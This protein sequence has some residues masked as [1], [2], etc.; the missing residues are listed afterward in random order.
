MTGS[1]V[2]TLVLATL[3]LAGC[4]AVASAPLVE[5]VAGVAVLDESSVTVT[6]PLTSRML[7]L[8]EQ[9]TLARAQDLLLEDCLESA[10]VPSE[11]PD[12]LAVPAPPYPF[13]SFGPWVL[14]SA[15][16]YGYELPIPESGSNP[17]AEWESRLSEQQLA[18]ASECMESDEWQTLDI[19]ELMNLGASVRGE[20]ESYEW[21]S[22]NPAW[23]EARD[24]YQHCMKSA[25]YTFTDDEPFIPASSVSAAGE[26]AILI[27]LDDVGCKNQTDLVQRLADVVAAYELDFIARNEAALLE[28]QKQKQAKLDAADAIIANR[29]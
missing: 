18:A 6:F 5:V 26:Q 17:L 8:D 28:E 12:R 4:S 25:G 1:R 10:G 19:T 27:A 16:V 14:E 22:Q 29:S 20:R 7:S 13:S 24:Q 15:A 3:A 11:V 9:N 2:S 23:I 21:A